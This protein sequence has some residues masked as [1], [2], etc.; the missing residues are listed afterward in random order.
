MERQIAWIK[1]SPNV[2]KCKYSRSKMGAY[3]EMVPYVGRI[4]DIWVRRLW[5]I[6]RTGVANNEKTGLARQATERVR[7]GHSWKNNG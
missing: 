1:S 7:T 5:K 2:I 3:D 6:L 4:E